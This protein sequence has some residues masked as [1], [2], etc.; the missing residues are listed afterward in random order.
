MFA[1][2]QP[3]SGED[4]AMAAMSQINRGVAGASAALL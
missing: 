3:P 4:M 1:A 2:L